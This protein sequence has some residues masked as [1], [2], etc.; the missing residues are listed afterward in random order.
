VAHGREQVYRDEVFRPDPEAFVAEVFGLK[1][2]RRT[3]CPIRWIK[4]VSSGAL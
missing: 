4:Q 2:Q 3:A 1:A